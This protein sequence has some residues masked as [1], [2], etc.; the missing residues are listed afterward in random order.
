MKSAGLRAHSRKHR[1]PTRGITAG[2]LALRSSRCPY[3]HVRAVWVSPRCF[4][5]RPPTESDP[6]RWSAYF[7]VRFQSAPSYGER[8]RRKGDPPGSF[9]FQSAPSY[10]ERRDL[11][12]AFVQSVQ[13][14][15]APSY[16]E[17][18]TR[19]HSNSLPTQFQSAPSYGERP[20]AVGG[21]R[22]GPGFNPR[23][24]TESDP[25]SGA[26]RGRPQVSIRALL[27]RAT[28]VRASGAGAVRV[29]IRALLR[30]ATG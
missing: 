13:F 27:R 5:P 12:S 20:D 22:P 18:P 2:S 30:R 19:N 10:G 6:F 25:V 7:G 14:Q 17:R 23:P 1:Y 28:L 8:P 9:V 15:S 4:N 3:M 16:G 21:I 24:P 26:G 11:R 29:S